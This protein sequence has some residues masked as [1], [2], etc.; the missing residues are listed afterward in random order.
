LE[1]VSL[2][3]AAAALLASKFGE[4]F[5]QDAGESTWNAVKR[6]REIVAAKFRGDSETES[7][8]TTLVETPTNEANEARALVAT[9][10]AE[11]AKTD[12]SFGAELEQLVTLARRDRTVESF[13]AQAFDNAKQVNFRGDN[14]VGSGHPGAHRRGLA[15]PRPCGL[16]EHRGPRR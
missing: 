1:P 4:R 11:A 13:L 16:A 6:L 7:A 12:S 14:L 2:G 9:R 3:I 10:I 8:V 5:A 15:R